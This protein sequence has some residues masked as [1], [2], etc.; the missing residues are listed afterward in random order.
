MSASAG[1]RTWYVGIEGGAERGGA[2]N[3]SNQ[4]E[5][6]PAVLATVGR[7]LGPN[8]SLEG[9]LGYRST[10][11]EMF[12][13]A[14]IDQISAMVNA[15]YEVPVSEGIS[16]SLGAGIGV[17]YIQ[18]RGGGFWPVPI[19]DSDIQSAAQLKF[20]LN[21]EVGETTDL[22]ANYRLMT[23]FENDFTDIDNST[24]TLGLRFAL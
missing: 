8:F 18:V 23:T 19:D 21:F 3:D 24:L 14:D 16:L 12:T 1:E 13:L 6:G 4:S 9:E 22:Y 15:V 17:D 5:I 20:G 11:E 7:K 2:F 10:N